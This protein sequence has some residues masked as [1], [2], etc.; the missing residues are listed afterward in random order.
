MKIIGTNF[1][2]E[3]LQNIY[4]LKNTNNTKLL[5]DHVGLRT[6]KKQSWSSILLISKPDKNSLKNEKEILHVKF[7]YKHVCQNLKYQPLNLAI[8]EGKNTPLRPGSEYFRIQFS[9][10]MR[11]QYI[12]VIHLKIGKKNYMILFNRHKQ[13]THTYTQ[14]PVFT[15]DQNFCQTS[16]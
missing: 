2:R 5:P 15:Y 16:T 12:D 13:S 14:S 6:R 8:H 1:C 9:S 10:A 11:K 3:L 7:I 4:V